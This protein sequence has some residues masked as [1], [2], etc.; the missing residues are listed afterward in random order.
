MERYLTTNQTHTFS[1]DPK[2]I[3]T[4]EYETKYV[5]TSLETTDSRL[6]IKLDGLALMGLCIHSPTGKIENFLSCID[7]LRFYICS[8]N[9]KPNYLLGEYSSDFLKIYNQNAI[10]SRNTNYP[11]HI[12]TQYL[13]KIPYLNK[14]LS[15]SKLDYHNYRLE[16]EISY[17]NK[18]IIDGIE[19]VAEC[20]YSDYES[21]NILHTYQYGFKNVKRLQCRLTPGQNVI[22]FNEHNLFI[23]GL[24]FKA[25]KNLTG[26]LGNKEISYLTCNLV[27]SLSL[28]ESC[29]ILSYTPSSHIW[30]YINRHGYKKIDE[31]TVLILNNP[32]DCDYLLDISIIYY[33][34]LEYIRQLVEEP[35]YTIQH[36]PIPIVDMISVV[37]QTHPVERM[38]AL[39]EKNPFRNEY[40]DYNENDLADLSAQIPSLINTSQLTYKEINNLS[41]ILS[42]TQSA[43]NRL[44]NDICCISLEPIAIGDYYVTCPQCNKSSNLFCTMKWILEKH[45]VS[46]A[47]CRYIY[48][49]NDHFTV[50]R[51]YK[52]W[53]P[54]G[55]MFTTFII[56]YVISNK[57]I[58]KLINYPY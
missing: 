44:I 19:I 17:K 45:T 26:S 47:H 27:H 14:Y 48:T 12:N 40:I 36:Q 4:L 57:L 24:F 1:T 16:L 34:M 43:T 10:Q 35:M 30:D 39:N 50:Y 42:L 56:T 6:H 49:Y 37:S 13:L 3:I 58:T 21:D 55:Y 8:Q 28:P 53:K 51:N 22:K 46:C 15:K 23:S 29:F 25:P 32:L 54:Y 33:D 31:D 5:K 41:I 7:C 9:G 11:S 2:P 18:E 20:Y 52:N 38:L